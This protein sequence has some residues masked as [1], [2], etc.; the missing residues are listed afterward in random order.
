[1]NVERAKEV[2][3]AAYN[4]LFTTMEQ[5]QMSHNCMQGCENILAVIEG[6]L[7]SVC[8]FCLCGIRG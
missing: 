8:G 3:H 1:M 6:W 4:S 5:V 2:F 7:T